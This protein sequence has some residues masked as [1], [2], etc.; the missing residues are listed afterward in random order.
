MAAK[1]VESF[2][3]RNLKHL[4]VCCQF[5]CLLSFRS[6]P[7]ICIPNFA[8]LLCNLCTEVL[9]LGSDSY[10]AVFFSLVEQL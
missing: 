6:C 5:S 1:E 10:S 4:K 9:L 7:G 8:C 3:D 2:A